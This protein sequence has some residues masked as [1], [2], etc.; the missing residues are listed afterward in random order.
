[1]YLLFLIGDHCLRADCKDQ[2]NGFF[3]AVFKR[4]AQK[5]STATEINTGGQDPNWTKNRKKR[6]Y[7]HTPVTNSTHKVC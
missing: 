5:K 4:L 6:K 1:M 3:I 7:K 2:T